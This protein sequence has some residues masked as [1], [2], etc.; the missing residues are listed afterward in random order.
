MPNDDVA[1]CAGS[2]VAVEGFDRAP[3]LGGSLCGSLE[4]TWHTGVR[5]ALAAFGQRLCQQALCAPTPISIRRDP[6]GVWVVSKDRNLKSSQG[7][8]N[9]KAA[10]LPLVLRHGALVSRFSGK[11]FLVMPRRLQRLAS[12]SP[13]PLFDSGG[14]GR[15]YFPASGLIVNRSGAGGLISKNSGRCGCGMAREKNCLFCPISI[16]DTTSKNFVLLVASLLTLKDKP[17]SLCHA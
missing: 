12:I 10:R 15:S 6:V 13:G 9:F 2:D 8:L 3:K 4:P 1:E 7:H 11:R 14:L 16:L 5:F 17:F